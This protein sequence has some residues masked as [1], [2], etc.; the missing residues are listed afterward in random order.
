MFMN[1]SAEVGFHSRSIAL[2]LS[3]TRLGLS[4]GCARTRLLINQAAVGS[5]VF[6]HY[7]RA[8]RFCCIRVAVDSRK[9]LSTSQRTPAH[10][11]DKT[12]EAKPQG[13]EFMGE[14]KDYVFPDSKVKRTA[15]TG[16]Q[17][18]VLV[19]CGSFSPVLLHLPSTSQT[20]I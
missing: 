15:E 3:T 19:A 1:I 7:Y 11:M 18:I 12:T 5:S 13:E 16:K 20:L 8:P 14:L 10:N 2:S 4:R 17:P 6:K 9:P